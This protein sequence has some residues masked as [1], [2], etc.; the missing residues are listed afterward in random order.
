MQIQISWL[1]QKPTD[2]DLHCLQRQ[3]ISGFSR[4][5]V[6]TSSYI[7]KVLWLYMVRYGRAFTNG[8]LGLCIWTTFLILITNTGINFCTCC[9]AK[10]WFISLK[11]KLQFPSLADSSKL[12][13][14]S[15]IGVTWGILQFLFQ[16]QWRY[17]SYFF[18]RKQ[19][20]TLYANC[21][22]LRQFACNVKTCFLG[23]I[24][25]IF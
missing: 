8:P 6:N 23:K 15:L 25:K 7:L 21:L 12:E 17:F 9:L 3:G 22:L 24:R 2:L 11:S 4:T 16:K 19:V 20:L 14:F 1:L 10:C 18:P 5:R 13:R